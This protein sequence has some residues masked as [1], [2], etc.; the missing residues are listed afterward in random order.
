MKR[1]IQNQR[2]NK[3]SVGHRIQ[4]SIK[5]FIGNHIKSL[6]KSNTVVTNSKQSNYRFFR[7]K[8]FNYYH[9]VMQFHRIKIESKPSN[10]FIFQII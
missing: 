10:F 4:L 6:L 7:L 3:N 2:L 5:L 1:K 9:R 8:I